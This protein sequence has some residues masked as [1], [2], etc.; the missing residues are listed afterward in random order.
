M[1]ANDDP[2]AVGAPTDAYAKALAINLDPSCYGSFAEIG[3]GQE[4]ARWFLRVGGAAGT[5]AQTISAY[6]KAFSDDT[7]GEG[8]TD[9]NGN[10]T[11]SACD[12]DGVFDD[13]L[14]LYVRLRTEM[15]VN[16]NDVVEVEDSSWIDEVY[17]YDSGIIETEGGTFTVNFMLNRAIAGELPYFE[18]GVST[19][20]VPDDGSARWRDLYQRA[21]K[22]PVFE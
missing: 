4:V 9:A 22:Q 13:E 8:T 20:L 11:F 18:R 12:D 2:T 19:R 10:Y 14:E 5:V 6:D 21:G 7:Y 17:E 1:T 3:A 15:V 16:G